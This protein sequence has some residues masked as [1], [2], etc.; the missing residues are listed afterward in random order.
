MNQLIPNKPDVVQ[1][2][3]RMKLEF[4]RTNSR[5]VQHLVRIENGNNPFSNGLIIESFSVD[6]PLGASP[7]N[8]SKMALKKYMKDG[9]LGAFA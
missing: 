9:F 5:N 8:S 2:D 3:S 6:G 4:T 1:S 7:Q